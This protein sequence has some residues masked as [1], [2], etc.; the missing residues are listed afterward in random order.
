[1]TRDIYADRSFDDAGE[2]LCSLPEPAQAPRHPQF[3]RLPDYELQEIT[4]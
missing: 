1:M 4:D 3:M 2:P